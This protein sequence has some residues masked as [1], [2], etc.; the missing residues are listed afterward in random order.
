MGHE[1]YI[2]F[3]HILRLLDTFLDIRFVLHAGFGCEGLVETWS[4]IV[5]P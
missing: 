2:T 1:V 5:I 3:L 4:E